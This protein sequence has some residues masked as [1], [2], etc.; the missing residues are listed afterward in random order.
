MPKG[1]RRHLYPVLPRFGG[2]VRFHGDGGLAYFDVSKFS[3]GA[4][5]AAERFFNELPELHKQIQTVLLGRK[6]Q[7]QQR[8]RLK[9]HFGPVYID[10]DQKHYTSAANVI[11]SFVKKERAIAALTDQLYVTDEYLKTLTPDQQAKFSRAAA[12]KQ[13]FDHLITTIYRLQKRPPDAVPKPPLLKGRKGGGRADITPAELNYLKR[14]LE[15]QVLLMTARNLVTT[16]LTKRLATH[17]RAL[18]SADLAEVTL[19]GIHNFLVSLCREV[20]DTFNVTFWR[21][22]RVEKPTH[23]RKQSSFPRPGPKRTISL[24]EDRWQVVR[25]FTECTPI[26]HE[27]VRAAAARREWFSFDAQQAKRKR[28]LYSAAQFP[29][30]RNRNNVGQRIDREVLGVLSIDTNCPE[31]FHPEDGQLW[32]DRIKGFLVNLALSQVLERRPLN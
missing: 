1:S 4:L 13:K 25:S 14:S 22:N 18:R 31:F 9:A 16:G 2:R 30:Y 28:N 23:L 29:I 19:Q 12:R 27:D 32:T 5:H 6:V 15:M 26:F 21:P 17:R 8:F 11:N 3:G 24:R 7:R 20:T 10:A